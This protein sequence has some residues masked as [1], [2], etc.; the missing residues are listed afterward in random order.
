MGSLH[1]YL[2]WNFWAGAIGVVCRALIISCSEYPR[3]TETKYRFSDLVLL[4]ASLWF[5]GW[6]YILL[7]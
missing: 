5:T 6:A 2:M 3:T 1:S 4:F 7:G